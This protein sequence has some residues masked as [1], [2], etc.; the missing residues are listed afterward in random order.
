MYSFRSS[1]LIPDF[2][3]DEASCMFYADNRELPSEIKTNKRMYEVF[4]S[5]R[6]E[7]T[8]ASF[9]SHLHAS[10]ENAGIIVFKDDESLPRGDKI[11]ESLLRAI[12]Q[13]ECSVVVFSRNYAESGWCM[14]E[15]EKIMECHRT[16]GQVVVPVF[17]DV[18]PSQ[19]RHQTGEFGKGFENLET[20]ISTENWETAWYRWID[21]L[22]ELDRELVRKREIK[23]LNRENER[24]KEILREAAAIAGHVVPNSRNESE[25]IK[26]IVENVTRLLDKTELFIAH[27]PVGLESRVQDI[28]HLL[29]HKLSNDVLILGIWGMGGIGKTTLAKVIYNKIGR[30][31]EGR[32]FLA[33]IR[34]VWGQYTGRVHLQKKLLFDIYKGNK[35]EFNIESG[36]NVLEK[37]LR[38]KKVLVVLDDVN[39]LDQLNALCGSRTW[40]GSGSRIIITTRDKDVLRGKKV[41]KIYKMKEM[42]EG[43]SIELFSWHAFK[44]A[45]PREDFVE[46]SRNV[47]RYSSGLPLALEVLGS[48]LFDMEVTEWKST[49]EKLKRIPNDQVQKKLKISYDGLSDD[50]ERDIFLDIACFFIGMDRNDVIH[51][52]NDCGLFA[53]NGIRILVERS[54]VT[55]DDNNKLGM[56]DLLR[57]MGRE[58]IRAKSPR[59]PEE[60]SRLWFEEDVLDVLLK[61]TGTKAVEGLTLMLPKTNTKC[62]KTTTFKMMKKLRLIQ[63]ANVELDGDFK[64]LSS[65]LRWLCWHE[66]PLECIPTDFYQGKL[67]S[68]EL[69]KSNIKLL[70]KETQEKFSK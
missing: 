56:H 23:E 41:N 39:E 27:N 66:C 57:D 45:S 28:I 20:R 2:E 65:D 16:I 36:E 42:N 7:D 40:F 37:R 53:E 38:H 25:A 67:V 22:N 35:I 61:E 9:V 11:S 60:R 30:N 64:N 15:L 51:I 21:R 46:L 54:L 50:T 63:L 8:R 34:E 59:V 43:E 4:L 10:L 6:G 13:S 12:E 17:Y 14:K 3:I 44:Q 47:I 62:F 24:R 5:F 1:S 29:D 69:E 32:S 19:V 33:H 31:F 52:L 49:L 55:V 70:W 58:I 68:I 26:T 18:D 48:Y